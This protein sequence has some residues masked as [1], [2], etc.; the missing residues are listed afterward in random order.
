M[1]VKDLISTFRPNE[2]DGT[3]T[4][5]FSSKED[6]L[7]T[8]ENY[9]FVSEIFGDREVISWRVESHR[10]QWSQPKVDYKDTA[11]VTKSLIFGVID[12]GLYITCEQPRKHLK[13]DHRLLSPEEYEEKIRAR[14]GW[15]KKE[16]EELHKFLSPEEYEQMK[17]KVIGKFVPAYEE[18][19]KE[20]EERNQAFLESL[21]DKPEPSKYD[22]H[23]IRNLKLP[24]RVM[25]RLTEFGIESVGDLRNF[26][27]KDLLEVKGLA[28]R[29]VDIIEH[30][31]YQLGLS[32]KADK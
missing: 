30:R 27:R 15:I 14:K 5:I 4:Y 32:L 28:K 29:G 13:D 19:D 7:C 3:I 23:D 20:F 18:S 22:N 8:S 26:S 2:G 25:N 21:N 31:L 9:D 24:A 10:N 17:P 6:T 16:N 12:N 1:L 11:T